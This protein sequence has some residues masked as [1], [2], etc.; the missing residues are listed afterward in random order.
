VVGV[1]ASVKAGSLL[2]VAT[3]DGAEINHVPAPKSL[4][5]AQARLR[6]LQC[7]AARQH[8]SYD[9]ATRTRRQSSKRWQRTQARIG[10]THA[11]AAGEGRGAT[12]KTRP[13]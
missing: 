3:P 9:P 1:D 10:R 13:A 6:A 5:A 11:R 4:T 7:K 12:Q 2:V 8:G